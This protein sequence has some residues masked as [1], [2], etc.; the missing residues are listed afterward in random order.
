MTQESRNK[1]GGCCG[2]EENLCLCLP[3]VGDLQEERPK[4]GDFEGDLG[5]DVTTKQWANDMEGLPDASCRLPPTSIQI[6]AR[7]P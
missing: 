1:A 2:E 6:Q 3:H 4:T 5:G 7:E